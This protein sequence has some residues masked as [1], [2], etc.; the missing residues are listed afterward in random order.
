MD[1]LMC[2]DRA[3]VCVPDCVRVHGEM[4][5]CVCVSVCV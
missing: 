4:Q 2:I 5:V 3:V 1:T